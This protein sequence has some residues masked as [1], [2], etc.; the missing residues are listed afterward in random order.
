MVVSVNRLSNGVPVIIDRETHS[1]CAAMGIHFSV[2]ARNET[3]ANNGAAHFLEHMAFK[4]TKTRNTQQIIAQMEDI[5]ADPNAFTSHEATMY[6]MSGLG[7]DAPVF[8]RLLG[9]IVANSIL[10]QDEMEIERGAI[11]QEIGMYKDNPQ[12]VLFS[13]AQMTAF[14]GQ[15]LGAAILGPVENIQNFKRGVLKSFMDRHYHAGN[16]LVA[17]AGNVDEKAVI[18]VLEKTIGHV[19]DRGRSVAA[20]ARY[21]GGSVHEDRATQQLQLVLQFQSAAVTDPDYMAA[22]IL[23]AVLA[24]GM[25]SR[26][27]REIREKRG[28]VYTIG[29]SPTAYKDAGTFSIYAGTGEKQAATL[30]PVLCDELNKIRTDGPTAGELQRVIASAKVSLARAEGS[31]DGRMRALPGAFLNFG[32]IDTA[33]ERMKQIEAVTADDIKRV[34]N[35][36]FGSTLTLSTVGPVSHMEPYGKI[37]QRL[38]L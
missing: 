25:S 20:P 17:V 33:A 23:S 14:K 13:N 10:P 31:M 24:G 16:M 1:Q 35:R 29:A 34:A 22:R 30:I 32:K 37:Q 7:S 9:D 11:I 21:V 6:Y 38:K 18:D 26:L 19:G 27:F 15:P 2:G 28:L 8:A 4:G 36:I 3:K 5:G 12:A